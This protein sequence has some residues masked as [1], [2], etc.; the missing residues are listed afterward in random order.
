[1]NIHDHPCDLKRR[2]GHGFFCPVDI[3]GIICNELVDEVKVFAALAVQLH[4]LPILNSDRRSRIIGTLH[5]YESH[6][7]PLIDV[8]VQID[9]AGIQCFNSF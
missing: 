3:D 9:R 4:D 2:Y 5:C 8:A 7:R 1:M 6:F